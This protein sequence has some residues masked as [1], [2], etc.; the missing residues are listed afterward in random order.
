M[1]NVLIAIQLILTPI[2]WF[3]HVSAVAV[4]VANGS[5]LHFSLQACP[6]VKRT[7]QG[8]SWDIML[9]S[10][11]RPSSSQWL[12]D[13]A[14]NSPAPQSLV[15]ELPLGSGLCHVS[16]ETTSLYSFFLCP[17]TQISLESLPSV[18]HF[19]R[20]FCNRPYF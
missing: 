15:P 16:L 12:T 9:H 4:L 13:G 17:I 1:E 19:H 2:T 3:I 5:H 18:N 7:I 20:D 8:D 11:A 10:L 6:W 14:H